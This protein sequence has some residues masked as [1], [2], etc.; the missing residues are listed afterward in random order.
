MKL[1]T[2]IGSTLAAGLSVSTGAAVAI[3][4]PPNYTVREILLPV[5]DIAFSARTGELLAS[6]RSVAGPGSGNT[7]S[8]L[9]PSSGAVLGSTFIGSEPGPIGLSADGARAF[10]GLGGSPV[11]RPYDVVARTAGRA[12]ALGSDPFL[13]FKYAGDIA[14]SPGNPAIAAISLQYKDVF[15]GDAGV[16]VFDGGVA[17]PDATSWT[18]TI[19]RIEFGADGNTLYGLNNATT[20][21]GFRTFSVGPTGL[22]ET[23]AQGRIGTGFGDDITYQDGLVFASNGLVIDPALMIPAGRY[24][25]VAGNFFGL[26]AVAPDSTSGLLYGI[27]RGS[28]DTFLNVYDLKTFVPLRSYSLGGVLGDPGEVLLTGEGNLALRTNDFSDG[29]RLYLLTPVP[30]PQTWAMLAAGLCLTALQLGRMRGRHGHVSAT[31]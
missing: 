12:F 11:V 16:V 31:A 5:N 26:S 8:H 22:V 7:L 27:E 25:A 24:P 18:S 21:F 23:A 10:V 20:E 15:P 29:G 17:L 13:G 30:E 28:S 1:A 9:D 3:E 4:L 19:N 2:L 14:V 6:V